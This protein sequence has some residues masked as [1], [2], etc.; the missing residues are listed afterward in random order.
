MKKKKKE[1]EVLLHV[2]F[3]KD[4]KRQMGRASHVE[5]VIPILLFFSLYFSHK[6]YNE[7]YIKKWN[8]SSCNSC[9]QCLLFYLSK[10]A[11]NVYN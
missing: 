10:I 4:R 6:I 11:K 8:Q 9:R 1:M 3:S 7:K 5:V 2:A